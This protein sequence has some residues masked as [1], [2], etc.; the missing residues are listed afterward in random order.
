MVRTE[1]ETSRYVHEQGLNIPQPFELIEH[2]NR[3]GIVFQHV[4]APTMLNEMG[5]NPSEIGRMAG[6]LAELHAKIHQRPAGKLKRKQ[7]AVLRDN[8]QAAPGLSNFE[9]NKIVAYLERLPEQ[10]RLCHGDFHPDNVLMGDKPWVIDWM[11]GMSGNPAGDAART[12]LLLSLAELPDDVPPAVKTSFAAI[13]EQMTQTYLK[14]YMQLSGLNKAE[15][16]QWM[17]PIAA[18]RLV[19]VLP[20]VEKTRLTSLIRKRLT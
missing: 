19:E 5:S 18:A 12:V 10:D 8:I 9:K 17:L 13:R 6:K 2:E 16:D 20:E 3:V 7:K 11:T 1:F 14:P 4:S 15:I